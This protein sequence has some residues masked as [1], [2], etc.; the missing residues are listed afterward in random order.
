M[1][2]KANVWTIEELVELT[3]Q[4]QKGLV[5]Y[6]GKEFHF[7]YCELAEKEEPNLKALPEKATDQEK[8]DWATESGTERILAM[9]QKANDKNPDG[10]TI[11]SDNWSDVPLTLRYQITSEILSYQQEATENFTTG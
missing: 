11:T 10:T 8:Q 6:R 3:D 1:S 7:Q 4:V 5:T 2:E 9:I